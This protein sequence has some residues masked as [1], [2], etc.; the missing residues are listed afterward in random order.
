MKDN[1]RQILF[2]VDLDNEEVIDKETLLAQKEEQEEDHEKDIDEKPHPMLF[3][4]YPICTNHSLLLLFAEEGL[5]QV[6]SDELTLLLLQLF[7]ISNKP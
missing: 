5:P 2:Y 6:L 1:E 4:Q 3:N 7:K